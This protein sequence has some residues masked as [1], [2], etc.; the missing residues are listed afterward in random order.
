MGGGWCRLGGLGLA[1][2]VV[3]L[4]LVVGV[5]SCLRCVCLVSVSRVNGCGVE[6][7]GEVE[8]REKAALS[9]EA[10]G[11]TFCK[12]TRI[13]MREKITCVALSPFREHA[14]SS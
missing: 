11:L 7:G 8:D 4:A 9:C 14:A 12:N 6:F 13:P 1:F 5:L 2:C 10:D 3:D